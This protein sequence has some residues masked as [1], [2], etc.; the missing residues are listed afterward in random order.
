MTFN[1]SVE[2]EVFVFNE[3][4]REEMFIEPPDAEKE[5][6]REINNKKLTL[7]P[8]NKKSMTLTDEKFKKTERSILQSNT[9]QEFVWKREAMG[10]YEVKAAS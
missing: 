3:N 2:E 10:S 4:G 9:Q 7:N 6:N 8:I 1:D 5:K